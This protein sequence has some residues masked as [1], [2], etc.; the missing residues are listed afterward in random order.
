MAAQASTAN[1]P[2]ASSAPIQAAA[3][4]AAAPA[5]PAPQ[6]P[7]AASPATADARTTNTAEAADA[8]PAPAPNT[9]ARGFAQF[10]GLAG[11]TGMTDETVPGG[12]VAEGAADEHDEAGADEL[13]AAMPAPLPSM[14][15]LMPPMPPQPLQAPIAAASASTAADADAKTATGEQ[16]GAAVGAATA[17][18][19]APVLA[20]GISSAMLAVQAS[21]ALRQAGGKANT[22]ADSAA[23]PGSSAGARYANVAALQA[24]ATSQS[25]TP[26]D[27]AN[28]APVL[29]ATALAADAD[30]DAPQG[31]GMDRASGIAGVQGTQ[32]SLTLPQ[33]AQNAS[34]SDTVRLAGNPAQWQQS[35]KEALG[36]RLQVH[37]G[38]QS[39]EAVIRLDPPMLGRIDISIRQS[40]GALQVNL[41]ASN[42]E[43]L[44]QLQTIGDSVR[45]DLSQRQYTDVAVTVSA[46]PRGASGGFAEGDARQRQAAR[47]QEELDPGRALSEAGQQTSRFA[48]NE[49]E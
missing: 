10:L 1:K 7:A 34:A 5:R 16:A 31:S 23:A 27:T 17:T 6:R 39:E 48:M 2:A 3:S 24:T 9:T 46:T 19:A 38:R 21:P 49:R 29:A 14:I 8:V 47:Q 44:R 25:G 12:A 37:I 41:S 13:A 43:V 45:Q 22:Q 20:S 36:D 28:T 32:G 40:A 30:G 33:G 26:A 35:L 15:T 4:T 18:A 42:S 11:T